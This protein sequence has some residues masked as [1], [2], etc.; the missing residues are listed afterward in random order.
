MS[1]TTAASREVDD[2]AYG[3]PLSRSMP[4]AHFNQY[5]QQVRGSLLLQ[6]FQLHAYVYQ[7]IIQHRLA[8]SPDVSRSGRMSTHRQVLSKQWM[9]RLATVA[10][11]L[12]IGTSLLLLPLRDDIRAGARTYYL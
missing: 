10:D 1:T 7:A 2:G 5:W 3:F 8:I 4:V 6:F 9:A 11:G 12:M